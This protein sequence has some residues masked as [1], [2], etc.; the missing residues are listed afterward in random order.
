LIFAYHLCAPFGFSAHSDFGAVKAARYDKGLP[1]VQAPCTF[2]LRDLK[3]SMGSACDTK[4]ER[5]FATLEK[6]LRGYSI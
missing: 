3:L 2:V 1:A 4:V 5:K 6:R